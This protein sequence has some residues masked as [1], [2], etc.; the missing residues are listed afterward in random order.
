MVKVN[1]LR[2]L[3]RKWRS[4]LITEE[5]VKIGFEEVLEKS[6]A[7]TK[8]FDVY[9]N[10]LRV[11]NWDNLKAYQ[12]INTDAAKAIAQ[13]TRNGYKQAILLINEGKKIRKSL[14]LVI[15]AVNELN[16]GKALLKSTEISINSR[17]LK[18]MPSIV[19]LYRY[20]QEAEDLMKQ[21]NFMEAK[22]LVQSCIQDINWAKSSQGS[23]SNLR[24][25]LEDLI[26]IFRSTQEWSSYCSEPQ[27]VIQGKVEMLIIDLM[28]NDQNKFAERLIEDF[29]YLSKD[30][31]AFHNILLTF[32]DRLSNEQKS[33]LKNIL[34]TNGWIGGSNLLLG[35]KLSSILQEQ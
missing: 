22:V 15:E 10:E 14:L 13:G 23:G 1:R 2:N 30:R 27:L 19:L 31:I 34:Q 20:L 6:V 3:L 35:L 11:F 24:D 25:K 16:K 28:E 5:E 26:N 9:R 12:K 8:E 32:K 4:A 18:K 29:K 7:F 33:P 21:Q 17:W